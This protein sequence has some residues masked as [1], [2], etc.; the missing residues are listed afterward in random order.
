MESTHVD[1]EKPAALLDQVY[2]D[3]TQTE[4][5]PN[6][7]LVDENGSANWQTKN[8]KQDCKVATPCVDGHQIKQEELE[9]WENCQ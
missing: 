7:R 8:I 9:Q 2:L 1:L 4:C 6:N 5:E 3:G